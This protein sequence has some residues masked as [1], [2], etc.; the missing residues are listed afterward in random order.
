MTFYYK[1]CFSLIQSDIS[2]VCGAAVAATPTLQ[3]HPAGAII[4]WALEIIGWR[5]PGAAYWPKWCTFKVFF[6]SFYHFN[7]DGAHIHSNFGCSDSIFGYVP[8]IHNYSGVLPL[9]GVQQTESSWEKPQRAGIPGTITLFSP[10]R[11]ERTEM[12]M[13]IFLWFHRV[14]R[15]RGRKWNCSP[16]C[17]L[18]SL[19]YT[20]T[21]VTFRWVS[22]HGQSRL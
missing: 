17:W 6:N 1:S 8:W 15:W 11:L 9:T 14:A 13:N 20:A 2:E 22:S 21:W 7:T 12:L 5:H 16:C 18:L 10:N 4:C 19:V 3:K